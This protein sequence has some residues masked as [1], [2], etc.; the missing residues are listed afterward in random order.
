MTLVPR[1]TVITPFLNAEAHLAEAAASVQAQTITDW[2]LI[3]VDDGS[4]DNSRMIALN[5]AAKD[6]RIKV[7]DRPAGSATGAAAARNAGIKVAC[8]TFLAFL[9]ADDLYEPFMLQTVLA[10]A[11]ANPKAAMIFG[12]TKW[13]YP[14]GQRSDWIE[15]TDGFANH[16]HPPPRI[17]R[18]IILLQDGHVPCTCSVLVR[19][20]AIDAI[21]GFEERF[22]LYEDQ[23]LWAKLLL[24]YPVYVTPICLSRYRQHSGS[25]SA[26]AAKHGFY[27]RMGE[28]PARKAFL[29]W[30]S[31]YIEKST[32]T[33]SRLDRAMRLARS[34][35]IDPPTIAS[36]ANRLGLSATM[37]LAK[38]RRRLRRKVIRILAQ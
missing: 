38:C 3:L 37:W 21:G 1:V 23:A 4:T 8:G 32:L 25:V 17:L 24:H 12:P 27:D 11:N 33:N 35:Y 10:A 26:T 22:G 2:E 5:A 7:L 20:A 9:D 34:P 31:D 19:R 16:M 36:R 13:W 18:R 6:V 15:T 29:D 28:H 14:E 30:L